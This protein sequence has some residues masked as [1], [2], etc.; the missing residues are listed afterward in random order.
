MRS[1][2]AILLLLTTLAAVQPPSGS[3]APR[4]ESGRGV[5]QADD[6]EPQ[7]IGVAFY[8]VDRLYD[9]LPAQFYNDT[10]FTPAGRLHWNTERYRRKIARTAETIDSMRLPIVLLFGVE[11]EQTVRDL[12]EACTEDYCYLHRTLNRLD[13]LDCALLYFGDRFI[14]RHAETGMGH[15]YVEGDMDGR[16]IGLLTVCNDR[17]LNDV[18]RSLRKRRPEVRLIVAGR[19]GR[20]DPA[21]AGLRDATAEAE[22]AG[23]GNVRYRN[24]WRMRDRILADTAFA[25]CR[26]DVYARRFLVDPRSG[27]PLPTFDGGRYA[28]GY[29]SS[30][31]LFLYVR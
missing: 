6:S 7:P 26:G 20:L 19:T 18:V 21:A 8:D 24:G 28:G 14:P 10:D 23:R 12:A 25:A 27:A 2:L 3:A 9:T 1:A 5:P 30:L 29:G 17:F 31:P 15:L 13:G 22:R 11:N 16:R 4:P